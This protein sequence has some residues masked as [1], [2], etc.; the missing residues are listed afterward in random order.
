M[1]SLEIINKIESKKVELESQ[2][3]EL[4]SAQEVDAESKRMTEKFLQLTK[5][6]NDYNAKA[7]IVQELSRNL[8]SSI[9]GSINIFADFEKKVKELGLELPNDFKSKRKSIENLNK[10]AEKL[11][12]RP[13]EVST[14]PGSY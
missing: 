14:N 7:K 13:F 4:G 10:M 6:I 1:K 11:S 2:K 3:V 8:R 12:L 5:A 9:K